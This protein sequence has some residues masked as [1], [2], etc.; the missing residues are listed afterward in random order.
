M[1]SISTD[2]KFTYLIDSIVD[3]LKIKSKSFF[4]IIHGEKGDE[5]MYRTMI[6]VYN[7]YLF[8]ENVYFEVRDFI[9]IAPFFIQSRFGSKMIYFS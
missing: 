4:I 6:F 3:N 5:I 7:F 1:D 2:H 9:W 8:Y